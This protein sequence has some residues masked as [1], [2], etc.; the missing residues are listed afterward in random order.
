MRIKPRKKDKR[1]SFRTVWV[2]LREIKEVV[3]E[4]SLQMQETAQQMKETD[5]KFQETD[6]IV[7]EMSLQMKE[8]DRKLQ[9]TTQQLQELAQQMKETDLKFQETD[10][11]FKETDLKFQETD[12]KIAEL[13]KNIGGL[14]NSFGAFLESL[15]SP[16]LW[17]LL[18]VMGFAFSTGAQNV[19]FWKGKQVIAE[20]DVFL[21]DDTHAVPVEIKFSLTQDHV[22]EHIER[23]KKIRQYM[24]EKGD[25]RILMGAVA[26]GTVSEDTC[27]YAHK[28]GL[29]V[30]V[31]SGDAVT[32]AELPHNF[33]P[34]QFL[35][36]P[37]PPTPHP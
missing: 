6:R 32:L 33:K 13:S 28:K 14:S 34:A 3:K 15:F 36:A 5:L 22:D 4:T 1:P 24:D 8:T 7:K 35:P 31:Q 26:G 23:I 20:V 25:R 9:E 29:Y 10:R 30:F 16:K 21:E 18:N 2:A 19:K 12:R 11:K 27:R 37:L 17:K